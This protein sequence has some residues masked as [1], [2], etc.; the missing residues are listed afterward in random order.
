MQENNKIPKISVI[1]PNYNCEKYIGEAIESI[2]NQ[3]FTDYEFIIID[4]WSTD[5][6]WNIIQEYVKKDD[7]IIA[8]K[9]EE[10]LKICKT[11]NKWLKLAKWEYIARMDSDDIS[12]I[13]RFEKQVQFLDKN[14]DIWIAGWTMQI[15]DENWK[16]YS[17]RRYNLTDEEIRKK[18]FRYSPFCHP[19]VMIRKNVL[20]KSWVYDE[21]QVF[22]EDY[23]LY[24]RIWKYSKFANLEYTLIKYRMFENN[25]TTKKLKDME[26][27][28]LIIR[29]KAV[30]EYWYKM[31][32]WD[33]IYWTLQYIS[34]YLMPWK[35]KIWLFNLIRNK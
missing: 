33:K 12:I 30:K 26:L 27:K 32:F 34:V 21:N 23:D 28:T 11:L 8:I 4:D 1:M 15:M 7:R 9:N 22:A 31:S 3:S 17:E 24:F 6:S 5:N 19:V 13:D 20:D 25:S 16:V 10:N 29:K 14:L 2:L 18:L 35:V